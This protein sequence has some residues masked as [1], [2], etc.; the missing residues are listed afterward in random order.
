MSTGLALVGALLLGS[1][2]AVR[3]QAEDSAL[4]TPRASRGPAWIEGVWRVTVTQTN[5]QTGA[6]LGPPFH[7]LLMFSAGGT[8]IESTSNPGFLPGQRTAGFGVWTR[9]GELTYQALSEALIVFSGGP[10]TAGS[11]TLSHKITLSDRGNAFT[12]QATVQFSDVD[13][14]P[15][16]ATPGC[17]SASGQR[18][19]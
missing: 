9:T 15:L 14:T 2:G 17:A 11:Q 12:D 16:T 1:V 5:C 10:F 3:A 7:S 19:E 18:L 4:A 6:P 13:G 8:M